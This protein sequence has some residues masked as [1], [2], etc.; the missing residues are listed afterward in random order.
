MT[1]PR[2]WQE[3]FA[4]FRLN[5]D[6]LSPDKA[7]FFAGKLTPQD[8]EWIDGERGRWQNV[9][10]KSNIAKVSLEVVKAL[11]AHRA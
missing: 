11:E 7:K 8:W 1:L 6:S 4:T 10:D 3:A 5:S 9:A 2:P